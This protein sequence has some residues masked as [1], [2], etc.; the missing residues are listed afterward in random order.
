M[1]IIKGFKMK[2]LGVSQAQ[3]KFTTILSNNENVLIVDKKT[4]TKKAVILSYKDYQRLIN[5]NKKPKK[6]FDKF[7][8]VLNKDFKSDDEK[9][10]R[11][12]N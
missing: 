12:I 9:Y 8:G 2:Q 5:Q 10:N 3:A 4:K 11:I 7:V 1:Y 6:T